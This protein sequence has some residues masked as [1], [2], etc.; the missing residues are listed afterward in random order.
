MDPVRY[1][2]QI[3]IY[4]SDEK[5]VCF[6]ITWIEDATG[7]NEISLIRDSKRF[8]LGIERQAITEGKGMI[9]LVKHLF[10]NRAGEIIGF[11]HEKTINKPAN[12]IMARNI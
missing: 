3:G 9:Q 4:L 11:Q 2:I 6:A 7:I 1:Y 8:S 12:H 5:G 10:G